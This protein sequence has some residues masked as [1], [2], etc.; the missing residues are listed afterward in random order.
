[1]F[2]LVAGL[3]LALISVSLESTAAVLHKWLCQSDGYA[4]LEWRANHALHLQRL[5]HENYHHDTKGWIQSAWDIP[6]TMT[7]VTLP[8]VEEDQGLPRLRVGAEERSLEEGLD[9]SGS[10]CNDEG[11][12]ADKAVPRVTVDGNRVSLSE[13]SRLAESDTSPIDASPD[14]GPNRDLP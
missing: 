9:E 5:A 6:V 14:L 8:T 3:L 10:L 7:D 2:V 4:P 13:D 11:V 1:M 12:V